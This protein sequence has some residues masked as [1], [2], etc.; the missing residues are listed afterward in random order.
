MKAGDRRQETGDRRKAA[1]VYRPLSLI[2]YSVFC[3][4]YSVF[5]ALP[6][7]ACDVPV[8][9]YALERWAPDPYEVIVFHKGSLTPEDRGALD[10]LRGD[11]ENGTAQAN[12]VLREV[13]LSAV[14]H[15]ALEEMWRAQETSGLPWLAL[16]NTK[17]LQAGEAVWAG[18]FEP[19]ALAALLD[20]PAR[21]EIARRLL[22]GDCAV[23]VLLESGDAQADDAVA[24]L[25]D[26]QLRRLEN[27]LEL[28][29]PQGGE[30]EGALELEIAFSFIRMSRSDVAELA[31]VQ[32]LLQSEWDLAGGS[33]PLAFPV[34][35][36]GRILYALVGDGI[37]ADNIR[38]A[39]AFLVGPCSCQIK[40]LSPGTDL[41]MTADW[42]G[43]LKEQVLFSEMDLVAPDEAAG[44]GVSGRLARN[45]AIALL[46]GL[47]CV[48]AAGAVLRWRGRKA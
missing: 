47:A 27:E 13:D 34:F 11:L 42:D 33:A 19:G 8:F 15:P 9:R 14:V 1:T 2:L 22:G 38:E 39:C 5:F 31:F 20:S 40:D 3:I 26:A 12:A 23:W 28:P 4:L 43:W 46:G 48:A 21:R 24:R 32:M 18:R 44:D 6:A 16:R 41:L 17:S 37:S 10:R 7:G 35:G 29:V 36:R 45:L 25:L 30:V